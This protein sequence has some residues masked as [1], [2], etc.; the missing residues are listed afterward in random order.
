MTRRTRSSVQVQRHEEVV[1]AELVVGERIAQDET[2]AEVQRPRRSESVRRAGLQ[3]YPAETLGASDTEQMGEHRPSD[4][5][6]PGGLG[7]VHRLD[8]RVVRV[9]PFDRTDAEQASAG[10]E[11]EHGDRRIKQPAHVQRE[12]TLRRTLPPGEQ[13][14]P[15]Q[16]CLDIS[17]A[18][19][20]DRDQLISSHAKHAKRPVFQR[21]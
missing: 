6:T 8:F 1:L 18:G 20:I 10:T 7:G 2:N 5:A 14:V 9:E 15:F 13:Q 21:C 3:A 17:L 16:Q 11:A 19:I 12:T 4:P